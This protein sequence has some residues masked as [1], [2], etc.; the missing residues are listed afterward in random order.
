MMFMM[1][2]I[3]RLMLSVGKGHRPHAKVKREVNVFYPDIWMQ[4]VLALLKT[5]M[6]KT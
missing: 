4:Q 3:L 2:I 1:S 5:I 6:L